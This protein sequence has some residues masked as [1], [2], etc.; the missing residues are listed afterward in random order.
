MMIRGI[1]V[2]L[3]EISRMDKIEL[4]SRVLERFFSEE[5]R[6]YLTDRV[7]GLSETI[8]GMYAAKEAFSKALGTGVRGFE[9]KEVEVLHSPEG[10]PYYIIS[11]KALEAQ[12]QRRID[13]MFLSISHD[14]GMAIAFAVGQGPEDWQLEQSKTD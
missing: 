1:G 12:K 11:G 10:Q 5:E 13:R 7:G 8:A 9:L 14:G 4:S 2:D 6:A 3:C